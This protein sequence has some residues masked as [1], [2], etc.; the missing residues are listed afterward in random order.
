MSR[1]TLT[2]SSKNYSSWSLRG[3]LLAKLAGIDFDEV[4][5]APDDADARAEIL[6]LSPSILVPCLNLQGR[7]GVGHAGDRR[8]SE[9]NRPEGGPSAQGS[10][11]ARPLPLHLRRD[12]LGLRLAEAGAADEHQGR[13][14]PLQDLVEGQGRH[15]ADQGDLARMPR[16]PW[17]P[18]PV[19]Q[20]R[21]GGRDVRAGRQPL[22]HLRGRARRRARG[23]RRPDLGLAGDA[24]MA[25]RRRSPRR[26]RSRSWRSSSR[27]Q[28]SVLPRLRGEGG[29]APRPASG[30]R[31]ERR[32][33]TSP[34]PVR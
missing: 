3:W 6:L 1:T 14:R 27:G 9:R 30:A 23:L 10:G 16:D 19:R 17:R 34:C 5:V 13:A 11:S 22:P 20:D 18:V 28:P 21:H 15:R 29:P 7:A 2:I 32:S 25:R 26:R 24:G 33:T 4:I 8:I 31:G 12:A